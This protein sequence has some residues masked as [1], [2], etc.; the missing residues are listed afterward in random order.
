MQGAC[1][2]IYLGDS[3]EHFEKI[4]MIYLSPPLPPIW[5]HPPRTPNP[6]SLTLTLTFTLTLTPLPPKLPPTQPNLILSLP[7]TLK[8][9]N[10][11]PT[12]QYFQAV[13]HPTTNPD[14]RCLTSV[15]GREPVFSTWYGSCQ[16]KTQTGFFLVKQELKKHW[17][18]FL[19]TAL[20]DLHEY[21][22]RKIS[23]EQPS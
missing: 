19:L 17:L 5:P 1:Y 11:N 23:N 14:W 21:I 18:N 22:A 3:R 20:H 13:T 2:Q 9:Q 15:I 6:N 8:L 4:K 16:R 12:T 10:P 7:L